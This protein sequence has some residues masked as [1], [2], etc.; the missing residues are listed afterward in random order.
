MQVEHRTIAQARPEV[1]FR[2]YEDVANWHTW[3]PATRQATLDG[4]LCAGARGRLTP[5]KGRA[6]PMLVTEAVN[7]RSLT[8]ESRIP[9][10]RMV[11]EHELKPNPAGTEVVHHLGQS[12]A[13]RGKQECGLTSPSIPFHGAPRCPPSK[14]HAIFPRALPRFS[15]RSRPQPAWPIGGA[16]RAFA[17]RSMSARLAGGGGPR[18][19][20]QQCRLTRCAW[21]S[22]MSS[23]S[24]EVIAFHQLAP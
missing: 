24:N 5:A 1:I 11:F 3:D 12:Q 2:I 20:R 4:P 8:V 6:V 18:G 15:Q 9:L 10:F 19:R 23:S 17:T 14:P 13:A 7:G 22:R 16:P 21:C